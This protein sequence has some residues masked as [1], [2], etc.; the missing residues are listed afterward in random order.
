MSTVT[1]QSG[2]NLWKIARQQ[3]LKGNSEI[4][5]YVNSIIA[6][7]PTLAAKRGNSIKAGQVIKLPDA[8]NSIHKEAKDS[9]Q[10][11]ANNQS[12]NITDSIGKSNLDK[13]EATTPLSDWMNKCA[14]SMVDVDAKGNPVYDSDVNPFDMVGDKFRN[15]IKNN[16]G[17]N[18]GK[19]YKEKALEASKGEISLYD[20]DG[21]GKISPEEQLKFDK[22]EFEKKYGAISPE[23]QGKVQEMSLRANVFM[24]LDKDGKVD[25]K[26]YSSFLYAMDAN[27]DKSVA[28]GQFT[29]DEY[30]KSTNYFESPLTQE[31]GTF[32][33]TV[34]SCFKSLF[35]YDPA[36][37]KN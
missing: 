3:G 16:G 14:D 30:V 32:R 37:K 18:A 7:N 11:Q 1:V 24:D 9:S 25:E 12:T 13:K 31:A 27:N 23:M 17:T 21:D 34:R 26:E 20:T 33:G 10:A 29:R 15:D 2:D 36:A 4:A 19:I 22:S 35:G 5:N 6:A 8:P 28:N